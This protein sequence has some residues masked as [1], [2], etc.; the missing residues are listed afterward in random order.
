MYEAIKN[1][2]RTNDNKIF[3]MQKKMAHDLIGYVYFFLASMFNLIETRN[4]NTPIIDVKGNIRG[5]VN[6][7]VGYDVLDPFTGHPIPLENFDT[8][9]DLIGKKLKVTMDLKR[10]AELPEKQCTDVFAR[11]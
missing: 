6:Y 5:T 7:S 1:D 4:D 2:P 8:M 10:A 3:G 9:T 11:Y